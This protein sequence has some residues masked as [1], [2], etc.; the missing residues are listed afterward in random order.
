MVVRQVD[1]EKKNAIKTTSTHTPLCTRSCILAI[2]QRLYC[3]NVENYDFILL[4]TVL[5]DRKNVLEHFAQ[6]IKV[7]H[8]YTLKPYDM[9]VGKLQG[10][11]PLLA[12]HEHTTCTQTYKYL[13]KFVFY[14]EKFDICNV[15]K[16][17]KLLNSVY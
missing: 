10:G 15:A 13:F 16:H 5:K 11:F 4:Q 12:F 1:F 2:F 17:F 3:S 7:G 9:D 8:F 14:L 6:K